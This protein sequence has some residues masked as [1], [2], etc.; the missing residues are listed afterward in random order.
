MVAVVLIT[1]GMTAF[2]A[3]RVANAEIGRLQGQD[4][5]QRNSRLAY[6]LGESYSRQA[7][8]REA[9]SWLQHASPLFSQRM[10][11]TDV[12]GIIVWDSHGSSTGQRFDSIFGA[13]V[14]LSDFQASV[15]SKVK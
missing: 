2:F 12:S 1:V 8:W 14:D 10:F 6:I 5:T 11:L 7:G 9:K 13:K 15:Q 4:H 3:N